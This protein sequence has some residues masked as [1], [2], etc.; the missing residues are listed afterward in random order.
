MNVR[1]EEYIHDPWYCF[2]LKTYPVILYKRKK[3]KG[4]PK[5]QAQ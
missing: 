1:E 3:K 5:G 2:I 4:F